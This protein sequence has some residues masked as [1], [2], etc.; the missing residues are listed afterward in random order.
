[1]RAIAK[2]EYGEGG[3]HDYTQGFVSSKVLL[4]LADCQVSATKISGRGLPP[5]AL[6]RTVVDEID[7]GIELCLRDCAEIEAF[8]KKKRKISLVFSFVPRCQGLCG[9]AMVIMVSIV[10]FALRRIFGAVAPYLAADRRR[11]SSHQG[12]DFPKRFSLT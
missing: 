6:A 11:I 5:E 4:R 3:S 12:S 10:A 8:G 1:M 2:E 7:N 9:S